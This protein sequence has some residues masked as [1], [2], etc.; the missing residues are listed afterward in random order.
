MVI[1]VNNIMVKV[2]GLSKEFRGEMILQDVNITLERGKIYGLVGMNGSGKTVFMKCLC[3]FLKP[4]TGK[5]TV[6]PNSLMLFIVSNSA[7]AKVETVG[8]NTITMPLITPG[9]ESGRI[10]LPNTRVGEAPKS[11]A[12]SIRLWSIF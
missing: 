7:M 4:T 5:V 10:T 3:G 9:M 1:T 2:E 11:C 12:A 6:V 8:I